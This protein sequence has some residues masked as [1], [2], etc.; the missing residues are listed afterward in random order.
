LKKLT[1]WYPKYSFEEGL[2][3][4]IEWYSKPENLSHYKAGIYN[5]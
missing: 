4:A 1:G 5:I 2:K 3:E